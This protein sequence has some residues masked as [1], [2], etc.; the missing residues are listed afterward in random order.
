MDS[1]NGL[2]LSAGD[3]DYPTAFLAKAG[4]L[5]A[6]PWGLQFRAVLVPASN[7]R[8]TAHPRP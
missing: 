2:F 8:P 6:S 7:R 5:Y 1:D 4:Y 3:V